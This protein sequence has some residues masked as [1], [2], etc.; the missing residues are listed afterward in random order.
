MVKQH[1][2]PGQPEVGLLGVGPLQV[3]LV[4]QNVLQLQLFNSG[5]L[6]G[7][8][9]SV[10]CDQE[11]DQTQDDHLAVIQQLVRRISGPPPDGLADLQMLGLDVSV[12]GP[13][14]GE[15]HLVPVVVWAGV[16]RDDV[17][18]SRHNCLNT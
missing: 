2:A 7:I 13:R 1:Q 5:L 14:A 6:A 8:Q 15:D 9:T 11:E 16:I 4:H 18:N 3:A 12:R 17:L 10:F